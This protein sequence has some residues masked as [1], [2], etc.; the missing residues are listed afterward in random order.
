MRGPLTLAGNMSH[1]VFCYIAL[2]LEM[3]FDVAFSGQII[4][5][6]FLFWSYCTISNFSETISVETQ[7]FHKLVW[8]WDNVQRLQNHKLDIF[9]VFAALD[10][11]QHNV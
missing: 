6:V 9:Q 5:E 7:A 8:Q 1:D 2:K 11:M 4:N 10:L 3:K